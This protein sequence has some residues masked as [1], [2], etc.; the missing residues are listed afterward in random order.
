MNLLIA[1]VC[2]ALIGAALIDKGLDG[3][4]QMVTA[5]LGTPEHTQKVWAD[6]SDSYIRPTYQLLESSPAQIRLSE[7]IEKLV[8]YKFKHPRLLVSAFTH[9][10]LPLSWDR[11]PSYQRLEFLG[12]FDTKRTNEVVLIGHRR[13]NTR[14][15]LCA[16]HI[17]KIPS[18]RSPMV[19]RA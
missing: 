5:I 17:S 1:D 9:P 14:S 18:C 13:R 19:D 8:K 3:A 2:E 12:K 4:T 6:Y 10:S 11:I 7:D 16:L 15:R